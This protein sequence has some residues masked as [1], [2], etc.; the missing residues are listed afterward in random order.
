MRRPTRILLL[1]LVALMLGSLLAACGG[2]KSPA[3][4]ETTGTDT[5]TDPV[6]EPAETTPQWETDEK[7]YVKDLI[8]ADV[9]YRGREVPL[10]VW[11]GAQSLTL[12]KEGGSGSNTVQQ[13]VYARR[14]ALESRLNIELVP[15]YE[16]GDYFHADQ[17]LSAARLSGDRG[18]ELIISFSL[19][20]TVLAQEGALYNLNKLNYPNVEMPWY[21]DLISGWEQF[22]SLFFVTTNSS[23][24]IINAAETMFCNTS[25][26]EARNM[27][28]PVDLAL[29]G[30]WT[31]DELVTAVRNFDDGLDDDDPLKIYGLVIDDHSRADALYYGLGFNSVIRNANGEAEMPWLSAT[32]VDIVSRALDKLVP[33]FNTGAALVDADTPAKMIN[34]KTAIF[35]G[36]LNQI[37]RM[38][39]TDYA[40]IPM[41]KLN[42][43]QED[44]YTVPNNGYDI[45]CIPSAAKD[46]ELA[47]MIIE[48][49]FS[50]DYRDLAPYYFDRYMKLHYASDEISARMFE[51]VR[52]SVNID[53]GRV[54]H[55][56]LVSPEG[57]WRPCFYNYSL[58]ATV[59]ENRFATLAAA[60]TSEAEIKL[61]ELLASY[62][63]YHN[64]EQNAN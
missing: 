36:S 55:E 21:P 45:W 61:A 53:F 60:K 16:Q 26:F 47:G 33:L 40:P 13:R 42:E 44:Y 34:H 29:E 59:G 48:A 7:G 9:D 15:S 12:P 46:P 41:P 28:T 18:Y 11:N 63:K 62:R 56:Y 64:Q 14:L 38:E 22:G 20:P 49:F 27:T 23:I 10:L 8:P 1:L 6:T 52:D 58:Q 25:M 30:R 31:L 57:F 32:Y 3:P 39:D 51:I 35:S 4:V 17:F 5:P 2:K 24:S 54:S 37:T 19:H 43:E 50:S